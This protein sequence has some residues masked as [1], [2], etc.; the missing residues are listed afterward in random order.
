MIFGKPMEFW[1][2]LIGAVLY[3]A[4]KDAEKSPVHKQ[5]AKMAAS[6]AF[7]Y[8]L[9]DELAPFTR[10]SESLAAI[11]I[12]VF[13]VLALNIATALISDRDL[14]RSIV[15]ARLGGGKDAE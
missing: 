6:G 11:L 8:S 5:L 7:A 15:K 2:A 10:G 13:G 4:S 1:I 12:T 14:I 9:A 3:V